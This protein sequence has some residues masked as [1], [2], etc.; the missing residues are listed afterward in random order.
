MTGR[1]RRA[2]SL[3][4]ALV[5]SAV[6]A[7]MGTILVQAIA[8]SANAGTQAAVGAQARR[9]LQQDLEQARSGRGI[10]GSGTSGPFTVAVS[11][12]QAGY[13]GLVTSAGT[14]SCSGCV[15]GVVTSGVSSLTKVYIVITVTTS[16]A[17]VA[18]GA[19]VTS[20]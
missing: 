12:Y 20:P 8:A 19:T 5:A 14:P 16:G 2:N 6:L 15:G 13:A 3:V 9:L 7:L 10:P 18:R 17:L 1:R 4:E 11:T